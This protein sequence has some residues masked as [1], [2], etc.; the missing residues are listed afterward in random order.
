MTTITIDTRID[1][2]RELC[3]DLALDV[4]VHQQS[5]AFSG[6]RLVAPGRLTGLLELGDLV[7]FEGRH[8]GFRHRFVAKITEL[9]R[10]YRFTDEMVEGIFTWLRHDHEFHESLS[11]TIMRDVLTWRAP[12][13]PLGILADTIFLRRHMEDFVT[14]KQQGL[15][16]IAE[17][18]ARE[19]T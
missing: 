5:A 18:R 12:L 14:R 13:G 1:A 8:L 17:A 15:K 16:E 6:E 10:P 2:P 11:G 7:A 4:E 9:D 3:F 19:G